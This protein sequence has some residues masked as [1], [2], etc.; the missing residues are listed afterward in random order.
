MSLYPAGY[1]LAKCVE[2]AL[3][4]TKKG[5]PQVFLKFKALDGS[6]PPAYFGGFGERSLPF[7][8]KALRACGW[9]GTDITD[10]DNAHC[11]LDTNEVSLKVEHETYE[12]VERAKVS[13]VNVPGQ[14]LKTLDP[15]KKASFAQ[16]LK[17]NILTLEMNQPK[18][19]AKPQQQSGPPPGHPA[20]VDIPF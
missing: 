18:P 16:A 14:A 12:G 2:W 17:A 11:G 13:F 1:H 4:E 9:T 6:E 7:T 8:L 15:A 3:T 5:D 20:G 19:A 10:I